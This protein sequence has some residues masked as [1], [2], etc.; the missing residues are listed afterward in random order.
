MHD[1]QRE[2][3]G[4]TAGAPITGPRYCP[5]NAPGLTAASGPVTVLS[6]SAP[7]CGTNPG[8]RKNNGVCYY[9]NDTNAVD[10]HAALRHCLDERAL[11][12]SI[13]NKDEQAYINSMVRL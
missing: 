6:P 2:D 11:L 9:Y 4:P 8:W 7:E 3:P 12:A 1:R 10:Y 13:H 5:H